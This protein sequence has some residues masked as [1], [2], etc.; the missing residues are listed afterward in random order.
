MFSTPNTFVRIILHVR[1][2]CWIH[3][4]Q[5]STC[6]IFPKPC[7]CNMPIVAFAPI[8]IP[9]I[10]FLLKSSIK[11]LAPKTSDDPLIASC[12]SASPLD[13]AIV[14]CVSSHVL[15]RCFPNLRPRPLRSTTFLSAY[16]LP[17]LNLKKTQSYLACSA[18]QTTAPS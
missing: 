12:N 14:A 5:T 11:L 7:L 4:C 6:L 16:I 18:S 2:A 13:V 9:T 10:T 1:T 15:I 3:K 17:N 8:L